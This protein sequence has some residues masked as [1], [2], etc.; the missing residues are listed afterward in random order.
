[1][2]GLVTHGTCW[3]LLS[4][5]DVRKGARCISEQITEEALT[6][7]APLPFY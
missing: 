6:L 3:L 4:L 5:I 1:V 2:D 7:C